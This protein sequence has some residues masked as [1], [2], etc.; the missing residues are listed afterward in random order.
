MG[1]DAISKYEAKK[2]IIKTGNLSMGRQANGEAYVAPLFTHWGD[3]ATVAGMAVPGLMKFQK[4]G[5]VASNAG[6]ASKY[7]SWYNPANKP[8][9]ATPNVNRWGFFKDVTKAHFSGRANFMNME[10]INDHIMRLEGYANSRTPNADILKGSK[11]GSSHLAKEARALYKQLCQAKT[12]DECLNLI[13]SR[14]KGT[15]AQLEKILGQHAKA[16]L[17]KLQ[18]RMNYQRLLGEFQ[19]VQTEMRNGR[20]SQLPK[21]TFDRLSKRFAQTRL[22]E[23]KGIKAGLS[24]KGW[25][26]RN[27]YGSTRWI[28][29]SLAASKGLRTASRVIGGK[30]GGAAAAVMSVGA[31]VMDVSTAVSCAKD[32]EGLKDGLRQAAKS[33]IRV[34]SELGATWAGAKAGAMI[35]SCFGPIGT[36]LGGLVGGAVGYLV[37]NK[38]AE[39]SEFVNTSVIEENQMKDMAEQDIKLCEAIENNDMETLGSFLSSCYEYEMDENGQI[40]LDENGAPMVAKEKD[41]NDQTVLDANGN[42]K[43]KIVTVSDNKKIQEQFEQQVAKVRKYFDEQCEELLQEQVAQQP[44]LAVQEGAYQQAAQQV[45]QQPSYQQQAQEVAQTQQQDYQVYPQDLQA[46]NPYEP[47]YQQTQYQPSYQAYNGRQSYSGGAS[48][49]SPSYGR[50]YA[51]YGSSYIPYGRKSYTSFTG[52]YPSYTRNNNFGSYTGYLAG[53]NNSWG[54]ASWQNRA[55]QDS[56]ADSYNNGN[57]YSFNPQNYTPLGLFS[58]QY[59]QYKVA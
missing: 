36:L 7:A 29:S 12:Y 32:G 50:S 31:G 1:T 58:N 44:Q 35:G 24:G 59:A 25:W 2:D 41:K 34:A 18:Q 4:S 10:Y 33:G 23:A 52:K 56:L 30:V 26:G 27:W 57:F 15:Y 53:T 49:N 39:Q 14:P 45:A 17:F 55:W 28:K 48:T 46:Y 8:G 9:V 11:G 16:D 13:K 21:G 40:K 38:L 51:S 47:V 54:D 43:Q 19:H 42:P 37:G 6:A 5:N 22:T 3:Y 20:A